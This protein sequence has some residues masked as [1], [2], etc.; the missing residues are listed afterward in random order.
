MSR[1]FELPEPRNS[2]IGNVTP[3]HPHIPRVRSIRHPSVMFDQD[4][5]D[6][7]AADRCVVLTQLEAQLIASLLNVA[8]S[9]LPSPKACDEA[10]ELLVGK[11]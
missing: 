2:H 10:I 8:R 6:V 11:R 5:P 7:N 1:R 3:L 4:D 9:H